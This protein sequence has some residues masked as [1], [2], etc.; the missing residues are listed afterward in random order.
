M[1]LVLGVNFSRGDVQAEIDNMDRSD[2][3]VLP[4]P[5]SEDMVDNTNACLGRF[6]DKGWDIP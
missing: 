2:W 3:L 6:A 4:L 5:T 1:V